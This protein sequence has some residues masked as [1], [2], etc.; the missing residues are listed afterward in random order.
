MLG[1]RRYVSFPSG[2]PQFYELARVVELEAHMHDPVPKRRDENLPPY[3][4]RQVLEKGTVCS[5]C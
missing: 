5:G 2:C 3:L 1:R 4:W